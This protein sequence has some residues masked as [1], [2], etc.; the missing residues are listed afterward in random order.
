[1]LT[2]KVPLSVRLKMGAIQTHAKNGK[3][4]WSITPVTWSRNIQILRR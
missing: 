4:D 1:M 3:F 2:E